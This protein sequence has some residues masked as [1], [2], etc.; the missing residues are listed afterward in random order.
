MTGTPCQDEDQQVK[1]LESILVQCSKKVHK[2]A[3]WL[4]DDVDKCNFEITTER[5]TIQTDKVMKH[6][7]TEMYTTMMTTHG[8]IVTVQKGIK[9]I[10][11]EI[12]T[13]TLT[14]GFEVVTHEKPFSETITERET[15]TL[16]TDVITNTR[17]ITVRLSTKQ[18]ETTTEAFQETQCSRKI[19]RAFLK[20]E[21]ED[22]TKNFVFKKFDQDFQRTCKKQ[23]DEISKY[24]K[25]SVSKRCNG[26]ETKALGAPTTAVKAAAKGSTT[27]GKRLLSLDAVN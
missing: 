9:L 3:E 4:G 18:F 19:A 23:H 27:L 24:A 7:E 20:L 11:T 17:D 5:P 25:E 2:V 21:P 1:F 10:A 26:T 8:D 6:L 14:T 22:L 15:T 16:I 12:E 13:T